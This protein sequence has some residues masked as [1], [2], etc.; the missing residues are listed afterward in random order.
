MSVALILDLMRHAVTVCLLTAA[1]LL[2]TAL[3]VGVLVSF[4]QAIT[5]VQEQTLTFVP[6]FTMMALVFLLALPWML[7]QLVGYL[8]EVLR[9]LPVMIV[10]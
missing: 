3:A 1:P 8:I 10:S 2:L 4:L 5:Q 6:K 9:G 7:R